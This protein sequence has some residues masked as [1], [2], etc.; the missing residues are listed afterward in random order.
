MPSFRIMHGKPSGV[1]IPAAFDEWNEKYNL[2]N[3][4]FISDE[5]GLDG[6]VQENP[7]LQ[8]LQ[9]AKTERFQ[10]NREKGTYAF[11]LFFHDVR[12]KDVSPDERHRLFT[13]D[14][15]K[16]WMRIEIEPANPSL[17]T[18]FAGPGTGIESARR[19][20]QRRLYPEMLRGGLRFF[21]FS[22]EQLRGILKADS[23]GDRDVLGFGVDRGDGERYVSVK[24][25]QAFKT[26][27]RPHLDMSSLVALTYK[28][29]FFRGFP[30]TVWGRY[31]AFKCD[32]ASSD[33]L[34]RFVK[35]KILPVIEAN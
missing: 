1:E 14:I 22:P 5:D 26:P 3:I 6:L 27:L 31:G 25:D 12:R 34:Q 8:R 4:K 2:E 33:Q 15:S 18:Y 11:D 10:E 7:I 17:Y 30:M 28:S 13:L 21:K 16:A 32:G 9:F 20:I 35:S 29:T 24:G 19:R 23:N